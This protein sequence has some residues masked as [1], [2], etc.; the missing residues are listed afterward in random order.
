MQKGG[1]SPHLGA[2]A[3]LVTIHLERQ[4]LSRVG[5]YTGD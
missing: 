2:V 1:I 5:R 3:F 4:K